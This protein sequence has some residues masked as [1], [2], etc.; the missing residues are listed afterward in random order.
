MICDLRF[1]IF[2]GTAFICLFFFLITTN[3]FAQEKGFRGGI[4]LGAVASQVDGD[5]LSG[6]YK[7]GLQSGIFLTNRFGKKTGFQIEIKFIQ[8]GSRTITFPSDSAASA[9]LYTGRYYKLRLNYVEVPLLL[10]FYLKKKFMIE[11]GLGFAYLFNAREDVDGY[12]FAVPA[13]AFKKL[14]FPIYIGVSYFPFEK[15]HLDFRY[16]YSTVAIRNHPANKT[17]YFDRGQYNNLL[18]FGMYLNI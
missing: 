11:T 4:L 10:N 12:G 1:T 5:A 7:G 17:W 8:K 18:S 14:D 6:F 15:F 3:T 9:N 16:S 2:K 13:P